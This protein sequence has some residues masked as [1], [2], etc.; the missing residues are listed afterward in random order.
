M[1]WTLKVNGKLAQ[2]INVDGKT[3]TF[4][5]SNIKAKDPFLPGLH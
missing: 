2:I 3:I 1:A 4:N 5:D